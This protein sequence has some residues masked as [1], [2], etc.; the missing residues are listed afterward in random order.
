MSCFAIGEDLYTC[1]MR[2]TAMTECAVV[3]YVNNL[4]FP[5]ART[6]QLRFVAH[7]LPK[8]VTHNN[9]TAHVISIGSKEG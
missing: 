5:D 2:V 9:H 8:D 4:P 6:K 3:V 1:A 7:H